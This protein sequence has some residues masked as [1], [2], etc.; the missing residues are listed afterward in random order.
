MSKKVTPSLESITVRAKYCIPEKDF[1]IIKEKTK[2]TIFPLGLEGF[3]EI[4]NS[5]TIIDSDSREE[6]FEKR[7]RTKRNVGTPVHFSITAIENTQNGTIVE[8]ECRPAMWYR[9]GI[10]EEEFKENEI[11]RAI[12]ECRIFVIQVMSAFRGKEIEPVSVY[13]I[14]ERRQVKDRLTNLGLKNVTDHLDDAEKHVV[15]NNFPESLTSCRTAFEK[16][17]DWQMKKRGLEN[18]NNY[19]NNLE[20]LRAKGYLDQDT[21]QLLQSYY[22]CLSTIGVHEKG[23]APGL[24]EAQMG[25]GMT[26]IMLEYFTNKLP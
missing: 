3:Y 24:Y 2:E 18:T 8:V 14:I 5:L 13:P 11:Q 12:L 25:Y 26:L 21:T 10:G 16:I 20:R 4:G 19:K 23:I 9:I 22:H 17:I 1:Q 15:Q 7:F 6:E